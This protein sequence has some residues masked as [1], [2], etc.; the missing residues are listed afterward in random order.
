MRILHTADWHIG[1]RLHDN[2]RYD[3]HQLF[4]DWLLT[5]I[6]TYEIDLLIVAGDIFDNGYP[7]HESQSQYYQFLRGLAQTNCRNTIIVGGNHDYPGTLN[8]PRDILELL[9]IKVIGKAFRELKY[10]IIP[11]HDS[12]K[13]LQA[14]VCAVP[15]L[16]D[17]DIRQ[18]IVGESYEQIEERIKEGIIK[19]YQQL[20]EEVT[21]FRST[22]VPII[23]TGHLFALGGEP[24]APSE[25]RECSEKPIHIGTLGN[26]SAADFPTVFDYIALGHLHRPQRVNQQYHIRYSGSPLPLSFSEFTDKKTVLVLEFTDNKLMEVVP[27]EVPQWR[28]LVRF[29]GTFEKLEKDIKDFD[30][31]GQLMRVWAEIKVELDYYEPNIVQKLQDL[32]KDRNIDILKHQAIYTHT[33]LS[34]DEQIGLE[35]ALYE[36]S[37]EEIFEKK[38]ESESLDPEKYPEMLQAFRE[39]L[40]DEDHS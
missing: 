26:I 18:A 27:V 30:D 20:A 37:P 9:N 4:L 38:C 32:I 1:H 25:M 12:Q 39:L 3:E 33:H 29:R 34:L 36:L 23:A 11:I 28:R 31:S 14:V 6:E 2:E 40:E 8:A 16:R 22:N 21:P 7:S 15:Y 24:S 17:K 19:H 5:V 13:K 35:K 10:Q